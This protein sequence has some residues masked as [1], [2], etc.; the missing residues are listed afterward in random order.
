[1]TDNKTITGRLMKAISSFYY[2]NTEEGTIVCRARGKFRISGNAPLP[3]D[4]VDIIKSSKDEGV[5]TAIHPRKNE[6]IRPS[7]TNLD[8]LVIIASAAPPST[9]VFLIDKVAAI[10]EHKGVEVVICINKSDLDFDNE[11][12][13][14]IYEKA[15]FR[16]INT[17]AVTMEGIDELRD[18]ICGRVSA[19]TGNSGVGKSSILNMISP[20]FGQKTGTISDRI[21]RGRH[22]TRQVEFLKLDGGGIVAD[23]PGFS[24]FDIDRADVIFKE[25]LAAAFIDFIPYIDN[26]R[27]TGCTHI[28]EDGCAVIDAVKNGDIGQSRYDSYVRLFESVKDIKEWELKQ[29]KK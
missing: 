15:G 29:G 5:V 17:S 16:V 2:V 18:Q 25:E 14:S 13:S 27:F 9:E 28:K 4:V 22:T 7:V 1:V 3:G 8:L 6:F 19:F 26:C 12:L 11:M 24:A 21:H 23:T 20:K 10:A